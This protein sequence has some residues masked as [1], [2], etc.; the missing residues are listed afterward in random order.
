MRILNDLIVLGL[1]YDDPLVIPSSYA[2]YGCVCGPYWNWIKIDRICS[3]V[4]IPLKP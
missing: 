4:T 3:Q 2:S 1:S